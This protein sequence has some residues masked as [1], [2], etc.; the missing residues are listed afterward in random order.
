MME[1]SWPIEID[2]TTG[3]LVTLTTPAETARAHILA[4]IGTLVGER[5]MR[6]TYGTPILD[7]LFDSASDP[8]LASSFESEIVR[9]VNTFVDEVT[10]Q[11]VTV[12]ETPSLGTVNV[13]VRYLLA[14]DVEDS[15][16]ASV[17][18]ASS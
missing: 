6:P 9:A 8:A 16:T 4:L 11:T 5:V 17:P 10:V 18:V 7:L 1:L 13:E 12:T 15:V 3:Q 2:L 14:N